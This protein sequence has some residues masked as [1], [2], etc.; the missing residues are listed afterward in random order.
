MSD[1]SKFTLQNLFNVEDQVVVVTGGGTGIGLMIAQGFANN[2]A[3]V[4][5]TSRRREV[6]EEVA[7]TWGSSLK[8]PK[9]ALIPIPCDVTDKTSIKALVKQ[10]SEKED[11]VDC[12]V[13]NAGLQLQQTAVEMGDESAEK[14]ADA[15][16]NESQ[17][18]WEAV[19]R[20]NVIGY[21]F[22]ASAFIP[23]LAAARKNV[24]GHEYRASIINITS[25][26][27]MTRVSQSQFHY[28]A[29]KGAN[30][31]LNNMLAQ[32]LRRDAVQ[33]RVN[34]IAPGI[35]PSE[36][37]T[38]ESSQGKSN[39]PTDSDWVKQNKPPAGRA[40]RDEDMAQ[41]AIMLAVNQYA[42]GQTLTIDGG[43]LLEHP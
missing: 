36:M 30:I 24:G 32:E 38:G 28:N 21:F 13:N 42:F 33:I 14:L 35:F 43:W 34:S 22:V 9:G 6:L 31:Q 2:G 4:Y 41:A 19:Y 8:H 3:R 17:E 10:I 12:L 16:F 29:S 37:T 40:G 11:H 26:S 25:M 7:R 23:L 15:L 27:G 39:I 5:I 1:N 20:T 18:D